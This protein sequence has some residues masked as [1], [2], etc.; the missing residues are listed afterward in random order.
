MLTGRS[1]SEYTENHG[2][3]HFKMVTFMFMSHV[4]VMIFKIRLK[5]YGSP[6][7]GVIN[8]ATIGE[9]S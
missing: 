9:A 5:S 8:Y 1:T 3:V 2:S 4:S 7:E 6:E